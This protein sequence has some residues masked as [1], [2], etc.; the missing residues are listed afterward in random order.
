MNQKKRKYKLSVFLFRRDLR[1]HDN[2][3]LIEACENSE[4][5][6]PCFLL[7]RL[8]LEKD[9]ERYRPNLIQFMF[10]SLRELNKSLESRGSRLYLFDG[11]DMFRE[12]ERLIKILN[13]EAVFL[14]EDYTP[15]SLKRDRKLADI[16]SSSNVD[17]NQGF[18]LLLT[19]PGEVLNNDGQPY[20]VYSWF[21][22][23]AGSLRVRKN[24][25]NNYRNFYSSG[26][27]SS[28]SK[29]ILDELQFSTNDSLAQRGGREKALI[30]LNNI[31]DY[32]HYNEKR[33][34]PSEDATTM[35]SAHLKFGTVSV[36]EFYW[37]V[38]NCLGSE[39][40]LLGELYWRDFFAHLAFFY[41][42]VFRSAFNEKYS[43]LKWEN[44][45]EKFGHW[46]EGKTGFPIVDAGMRQLNKTGWMHNR[47][48]MI[49]A[50]FLTKD[51]HIDWKW[52]ERYFASTLVD[53]DPCSNNGGWQWAA[54]TGADS[55]PYFRIFNPWRQQERFDPDALYIK[56]YI[57]EIKMLGS[58]AIHNIY[59]GKYRGNSDYPAPIVDHEREAK[60][61]KETYKSV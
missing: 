15:Y 11:E 10:E 47:I 25:K 44:D 56:R 9:S 43:D 53:Y 31:E 42:H 51:L 58:S 14:N 55:Q 40:R 8:L 32:S 3:A 45:A 21:F 54:S 16:C 37:K 1:L 61:A 6:V 52:G 36:R 49:V 35:L 2:T 27:E 46:C 5:V 57:P 41:P 18:D 7:D 39:N 22:K 13:P 30:R 4:T 33:D 34:I 23:T 17:F 28:R 48:R 26:I 19:K 59:M 12:F 38:K 24:R 60:I 20:R 29:K 50:S